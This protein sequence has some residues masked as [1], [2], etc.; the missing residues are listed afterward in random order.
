MT[1]TELYRGGIWIRR[2]KWSALLLL[3]GLILL[4]FLLNL[5]S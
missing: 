2:V 3:I 4:V 1:E 5:G